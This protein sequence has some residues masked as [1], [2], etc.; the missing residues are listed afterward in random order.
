MAYFGGDVIRKIRTPGRL[1]FPTGYT[2]AAIERVTSVSEGTCLAILNEV[3]VP[4]L[5]DT[6]PAFEGTGVVTCAGG[7]YLRLAYASIRKLR[8]LNAEIPVQIWY[9]N[10]TELT[11]LESLRKFDNLNV[12]FCNCQPFFESEFYRHRTGWTSKSI[13]V[14]HSPFRHVLFLDAD[15]YPLI[16][17]YEV[18]SHED[19]LTHGMLVFPDGKQCRDSNRLF[20]ALGIKFTAEF[21][22]W[23]AG[24]F[25]LDKVKHW[26]ALQL[27][28]WFNNHGYLFHQLWFG[29][30]DALPLAAIKLEEPFITGNKPT[31]EGWGY[32]H[33]LRDGTAVFRHCLAPKRG[34]KVEPPVDLQPFLEEYDAK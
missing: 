22:E 29:D 31:W 4:N 11:P 10:E 23:E 15:A 32:Q 14:K 26:K 8:E 3:I 17:P 1:K 25:L 27:Y 18:F 13:A 7:K 30:K 6:P 5:S 20:N 12:Q 21:A 9:M 16:D 19:Y 33:Y 34:D 28:S 2:P 24:Q